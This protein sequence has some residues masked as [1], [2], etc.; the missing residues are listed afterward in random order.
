MRGNDKQA[1]C[2]QLPVAACQPP[3]CR[4]HRAPGTHLQGTACE[5]HAHAPRLQLALQPASTGQGAGPCWGGC[6]PGQTAGWAQQRALQHQTHQLVFCT[7]D[8]GKIAWTECRVEGRWLSPEQSAKQGE[9]GRARTGAATAKGPPQ[10]NAAV[11]YSAA[12]P[13]QCSSR[14]QTKQCHTDAAAL[15]QYTSST[16]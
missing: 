7:L 15:Q 9:C 10:R 11:P 8:P 6:K 13:Y 2:C 14:I 16:P 12:V 1:A 5:H 4:L 3:L